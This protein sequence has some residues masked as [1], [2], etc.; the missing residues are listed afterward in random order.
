MDSDQARLVDLTRGFLDSVR[1]D[2]ETDSYRQRL[3]GSSETVL[4]EM[5]EGEAKAFWLNLYNAVA[6]AALRENPSRWS[7]K[8]R[9]FGRERV[10]VAG[11][12]LSLDDIEHG[13]LRGSSSKYGLGYLSRLFPDGFERRH[14]L[15]SI[16]P[17]IHFALNCGAASCPAI[18]QHAL[19]A[20]AGP[21]S[22]V[23]RRARWVVLAVRGSG[24]CGR[25]PRGAFPQCGCRRRIRAPRGVHGR[26]RG[27]VAGRNRRRPVVCQSM[28]VA[29]SSAR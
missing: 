27:A 26:R 19:E 3:A 2:D 23:A 16:D 18:S 13:I 4:Q 1:R 20:S 24:Y 28:T 6:Q 15:S 22:R 17:R 25:L 10:G 12:D 9:F 14:R 21:T 7:S 11:H 8:R 29:G 5:G